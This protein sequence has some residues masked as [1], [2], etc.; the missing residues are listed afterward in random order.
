MLTTVLCHPPTLS[1]EP[2]FSV[3]KSE[4]HLI[5]FFTIKVFPLDQKNIFTI[6]SNRIISAIWIFFVPASNLWLCLIAVN[7][8]S[9]A[10]SH[11]TLIFPLHL[12]H[13]Y[14]VYYIARDTFGHE[15][16]QICVETNTRRTKELRWRYL[17]ICFIKIIW[18]LFGFGLVPFTY[19][20]TPSQRTEI[21]NLT[22]NLGDSS[23]PVP[24]IDKNIISCWF[25]LQF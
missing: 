15:S 13:S 9:F 17:L 3:T 4:F 1:H 11:L 2:A 25:L 24:L 10:T 23:Y 14:Y 8:M 19:W 18:G 12:Q 16:H 6:H 7:M 5:V 22:D 21:A 20:V